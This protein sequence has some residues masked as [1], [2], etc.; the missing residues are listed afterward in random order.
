MSKSPGDNDLFRRSC[1]VALGFALIAQDGAWAKLDDPSALFNEGIQ[2][3]LGGNENA[4]KAFQLFKKA[5]DRGFAEAQFN[6][7]VM[8][9]SGRGVERNISQAATWYARSAA[10]GNQ[11]AAFNLGQLYEDGQGVPRN[12]EVARAWYLTSGLP[13][14]KV[15]AAK[16][17][18]QSSTGGPL[19]T[20]QCVWPT[21]GIRVDNADSLELVWTSPKQTEAVQFVVEMR[22]IAGTGSTEVF[23][24]QTDTTSTLAHMSGPRGEYIWRVLAVAPRAG[25][26]AASAWAH[27]RVVPD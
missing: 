24:A 23:S 6:V 17:A 16:M 20:P 15:R 5:A 12:A 22:L 21:D 11:R 19:I 26:Y 10:H 1:M 18:A 27:F 25:N 3:D 9:D 7:G 13:A 4:S 14:A 2:L 8:L